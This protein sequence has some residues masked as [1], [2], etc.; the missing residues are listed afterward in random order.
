MALVKDSMREMEELRA[1]DV[2]DLQKLRFPDEVALP[3][4]AEESIV[5]KMS[6]Q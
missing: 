1:Q 4:E 3:K 6:D 5:Q 2:Q